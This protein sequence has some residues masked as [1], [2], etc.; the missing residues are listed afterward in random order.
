MLW[1]RSEPLNPPRDLPP[2][3]PG[4]DTVRQAALQASWRRDRRVAQRRIAWR[5][6]VWYFQ[7]Y[8]PHVLVGFAVLVGAAYLRGS[9]PPLSGNGE[10][11]TGPEANVTRVPYSPPSVPVAQPPAPPVLQS[12]EMSTD[13][14]LLLRASS[15]LEV[16]AAGP[17]PP[18]DTKISTDTLS[19]TPENWLHS[20]EP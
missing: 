20:K 6:V 2:T 19:L 11:P 13:L 14:P 18:A 10:Q 9:L 4:S 8:S 7:R 12:Q 3:I 1:Q 15:A 16:H 5:W 17:S